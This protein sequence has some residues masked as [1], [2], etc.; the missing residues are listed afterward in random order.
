MDV[1]S[2]RRRRRLIR[3]RI[4]C[5]IL[6]TRPSSDDPVCTWPGLPGGPLMTKRAGHSLDGPINLTLNQ[7]TVYRRPQRCW[8]IDLSGFI[9]KPS[10]V[11]LGR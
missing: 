1:H 8:R 3:R 4:R 9:F 10:S 5:S 2:R 6:A 7:M 11:S